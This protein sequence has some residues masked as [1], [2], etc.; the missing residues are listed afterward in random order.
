MGTAFS[1]S[2]RL[3]RFR[4]ELRRRFVYGYELHRYKCGECGDRD[5]EPIA[6]LSVNGSGLFSGTL[7]LNGGSAVAN[8]AI[9]VAGALLSVNSYGLHNTMSV[10]GVAGTKI[11]GV[12]NDLTDLTGGGGPGSAYGVFNDM[13]ATADTKFQDVYGQYTQLTTYSSSGV[14]GDA[15]YGNY[16]KSVA[17]STGGQQYAYFADM[18]AGTAVKYGLYLNGEAIDYISGSVGIGTTTPAWSLDIASTTNSTTMNGQFALTDMGAGANLKH[19]LLSS[20][21]GNFYLGTSSDAYAT[22]TTPALTILGSNKFVGIGTS[23]P[24]VQLGVQGIVAAQSFNADNANATSTF[25]GNFAVNGTASTTNLIVSNSA[26]FKN[27]SGTSPAVQR[28]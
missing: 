17:A 25:A 1:E 14:G 16:V 19:W 10:S 6:A 5:D 24:Y 8:T 9:N 26:V 27:L 4:T 11:Y 15:G 13:K 22:S 28:V 12:Y 23:S 7:G 18:T 21:G 2:D 20:E 3:E